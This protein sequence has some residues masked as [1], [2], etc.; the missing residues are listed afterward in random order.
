MIIYLHFVQQRKNQKNWC[1]N[2]KTIYQKRIIKDEDKK[3]IHFTF[4]IL[5]STNEETN[6]GIKNNHS[7]PFI[8]NKDPENI[9]DYF[10]TTLK[11]KEIVSKKSINDDDFSGSTKTQL[12]NGVVKEESSKE[13]IYSKEIKL[14]W[15]SC[16]KRKERMKRLYSYY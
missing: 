2:I 10:E 8:N 3:K 1:L 6:I 13:I 7:T 5:E 15:L 12:D 4:S 11:F 14:K 16:S 9:L